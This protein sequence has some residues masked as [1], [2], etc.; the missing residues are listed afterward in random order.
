MV[1]AVFL[2][3]CGA[4]EEGLC[5]P[6]LQ[7]HL[8]WWQGLTAATQ[9]ALRLGSHV[10]NIHFIIDTCLR[11]GVRASVGVWMRSGGGGEREGGGQG[12]REGAMEDRSHGAAA[13]AHT[14][15]PRLAKETLR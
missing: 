2:Y 12:E 14:C 13:R 6:G 5:G 4:T 7:K 3:R 9:R 8:V 15:H 11:A 1:G 10:P